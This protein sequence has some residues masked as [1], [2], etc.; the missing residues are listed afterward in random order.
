MRPVPSVASGIG[1]SPIRCAPGPQH[2]PHGVMIQVRAMVNVRWMFLAVALA[3]Q[4]A[5]SQAL[6]P[7]TNLRIV[8]GSCP[9][10]QIG[11]PPN[12]FP[13]PPAPV[14]AGKHWEVVYS[15]EFNGTSLDTTKLTPC[16]DWNYGACTASFNQGKER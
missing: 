10:G 4:I 2:R 8:T 15:E 9:A 11:A 6:P 16:F 1:D 12:C 7:P 3:P 13:A 5:L 14:G